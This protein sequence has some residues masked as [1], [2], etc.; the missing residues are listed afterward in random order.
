MIASYQLDFSD[1]IWDSRCRSR[2]KFCDAAD[3]GILS[4]VHKFGIFSVMLAIVRTSV[5]VLIKFQLKDRNGCLMPF[6]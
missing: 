2:Y 5:N 3:K 6:I 1:H 4:E